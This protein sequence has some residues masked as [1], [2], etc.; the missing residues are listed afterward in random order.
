MRNSL[1]LFN[2]NIAQ[3]REISV[4]Y[5]YL[6][7]TVAI[8][9]QFDDLL[10]SQL[11]YAV[12]A[13]DKLMHDLV[14]IGMVQSFM[15]VR[16]RTGKYLSEPISMQVHT[17]MVQATIPPKEHVFEQALF[18]KF[19]VVSF[20]DPTKIADGLSYIWDESQKWQKI[21][22]SL[23]MP[24]AAVRT[25]L[26]L[27]ADRRNAIVHEADIDPSTNTKFPIGKVE[28]EGSL[29]FLGA[30]GNAIANLVA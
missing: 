27:I 8:P 19:K 5:D 24:D 17:E 6:V 11:V 12:S 20:Q 28:S 25:R 18:R 9:Q 3:A 21:A 22:A 2:S 23:G 1:T 29:D 14:R 7:A 13:F 26:K 4:L 30:C 16:P 15:G 10:R